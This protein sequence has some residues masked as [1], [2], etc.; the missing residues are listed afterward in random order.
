MK[1]YSIMKKKLYNQPELEVITLKTEY[2]MEG[3]S[4]SPGSPEDTSNPPQ[5]HMPR[6]GTGIE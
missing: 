2:L 1:G 3:I 6:R 5:P 4:V